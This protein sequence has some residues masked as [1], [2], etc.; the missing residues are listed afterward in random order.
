MFLSFHKQSSFLHLQEELVDLI[1]YELHHIVTN[2]EKSCFCIWL[3][4]SS[5]IFITDAYFQS[6]N[7]FYEVKDMSIIL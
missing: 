7:L 2:A 1:R 3:Y 4:G 5:N 6:L